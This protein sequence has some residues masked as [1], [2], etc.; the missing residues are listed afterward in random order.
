MTAP[1]RAGRGGQGCLP[2]CGARRRRP[3][4]SVSRRPS[5]A[6]PARSPRSAGRPASRF[7]TSSRSGPKHSTATSTACRM[8]RPVHPAEVASIVLRPEIFAHTFGRRRRAAAAS[9][10]R[11]MRAVPSGGL[12]RWSITIVRSG[13]ALREL[14][15]VAEVA[16]EDAGKLEHE[17]AVFDRR[18]ALEHVAREDPVRIVLLVDQMA[19][20]S[21]LRAVLPARRAGPPP[22]GEREI[23]PRGDGGDPRVA[24][25]P[26]AN[27]A[28]VSLS[29]QADWT[30]IVRSIPQASSS[31]RRS[32]GSKVRGRSPRARA[33]STASA[34]AG[35]S[36]N[37]GGCRRQVELASGGVGEWSPRRVADAGGSCRH[38]EVDDASRRV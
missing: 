22:S 7:R 23:D 36:R 1:R 6:R 26:A 20:P 24:R 27:I 15:Q 38:Q 17:A 8:S 19:D 10:S 3:R 31:G 28:S 5:R 16:R 25:P 11:P 9:P 34:P 30:R 37:A 33:S 14:G 29:V 18:E 35:G 4:P 12:P 13:E 2:V 32:A 21:Q